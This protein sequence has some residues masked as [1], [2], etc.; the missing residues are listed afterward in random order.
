MIPRQRDITLKRL[1][2]LPTTLQVKPYRINGRHIPPTSLLICNKH[3]P[4]ITPT[5]TLLPCTLPTNR[6]PSTNPKHNKATLLFHLK[7]NILNNCRSKHRHHISLR[8]YPIPRRRRCL[9]VLP[10]LHSCPRQIPTHPINDRIA[11]PRLHSSKRARLTLEVALRPIRQTSIDN[12]IT[13]SSLCLSHGAASGQR[14]KERVG[15]IERFRD[16]RKAFIRSH[17]LDKTIARSQPL[18]RDWERFGASENVVKMP[19][20]RCHTALQI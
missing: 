19:T 6:T 9:R 2:A 16:L 12:Q 17:I 20:Q 1:V 3:K 5:I 8:Q 15:K 10:I 13:T 7:S 14:G 11:L 4:R 18:R